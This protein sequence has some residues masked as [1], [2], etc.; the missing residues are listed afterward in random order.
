MYEEIAKKWI[1][2]L[3]SDKYEQGKD[4]LCRDGKFCCLGVLCELAVE[5]SV[6]EKKECITGIYYGIGS[7][8][9]N[10]VLPIPVMMWTNINNP[11]GLVPSKNNT[12]A[13]LND[14]GTT[15]SEIANIIE[16]N[17]QVL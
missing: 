12:L 4:R 14:N 2:A 9:N 16:Q 8:I 5:A 10:Q 1:T 3:R 6:C 17:W 15:F 13:C 11:Q 7:Y